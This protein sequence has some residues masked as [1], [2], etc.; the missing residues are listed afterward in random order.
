MD[1]ESYNFVLTFEF[2][3]SIQL[4]PYTTYLVNINHV[5]NSTGWWSVQFCH[6]YCVD[7]KLGYGLE[8]DSWSKVF[9]PTL[10]VNALEDILP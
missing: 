5:L 3:G 8:V 10:V 7:I 2:A 6:S 4:L 1:V 9:S